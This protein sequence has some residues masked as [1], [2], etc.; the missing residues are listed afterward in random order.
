M[1]AS[2]ILSRTLVPTLA[3]YLLRTRSISGK[4]VHAT[5][6]FFSTRLR[7]RVR[8][9]PHGYQRLLTTLVYR[10]LMFVPVFIL[11]CVT[12]FLLVPFLGQDFFPSTDNGQMLLHVRAKTGTRIEET[13][14]LFDRIDNYLR[15]SIPQPRLDNIMDNIGMPY[16]S[17]NYTYNRS[18]LIGSREG[19]ILVS[20][21]ENHRPTPNYVR[22]IPQRSAAAVPRNELLFSAAGYR[23]TDPELRTS[24]ARRHTV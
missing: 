17:I 8:A 15:S 12:G 4:A 21:K 20:L 23:D 7:A 6:L 2:Y 13:A 22:A 10:R 1:L 18:G 3:M 24:R 9:I 16:S 11:I 5:H 19:D 14:R